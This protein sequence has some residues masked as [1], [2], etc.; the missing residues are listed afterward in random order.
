MNTLDPK[1]ESSHVYLGF[2]SAIAEALFPRIR[3]KVLA[4]L[5]MNPER[6]FY[7]R[8]AARIIGDSPSSIQ[9]ELKS[10]TAAGVLQTEPI[11]IQTFYRANRESPVYE[12][13]K[14]IVKKTFG[15]ADVL[16]NTLSLHV[17]KIRLAWIDGSATSGVDTGRGDISLT[18][19]GTLWVGDLASIVEPVESGIGRPIAP[20]LFTREDFVKKC[21]SDPGFL[22]M[23]T[24]S[25]KVFIIGIQDELDALIR[26]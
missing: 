26:K 25:D 10:L 9:R 13:L 6:Q 4:L 12:E 8:E 19:I 20:D 1:K 18:I 17:D 21:E 5:M 23:V 11:G 7:F 24:G 15:V 22:T 3:G 2:Q 14:S 16:K